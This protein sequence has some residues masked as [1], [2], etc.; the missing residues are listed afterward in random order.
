MWDLD[1]KQI[2]DSCIAW[3]K[4]LR[5]VW[6]LPN[7][8]KGDMLSLISDSI[9]VYDELC[10]RFLNFVFSCMNCGFEL[11]RFLFGLVFTKHV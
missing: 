3:R 10:R 6:R 11:V 9:P 5:R 8:T 1:N 2:N 7:T 4:G